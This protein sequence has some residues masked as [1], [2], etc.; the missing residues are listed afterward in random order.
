MGGVELGGK[1]M[2][3]E[4]LEGLGEVGGVLVFLRRINR[5]FQNYYE[6]VFTGVCAVFYENL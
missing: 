2:G 5:I 1:G 3:S 4:V 6:S